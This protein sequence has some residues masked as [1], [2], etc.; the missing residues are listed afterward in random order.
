MQSREES[1]CFVCGK[2]VLCRLEFDALNIDPRGPCFG[3][4]QLVVD[5]KLQQHRYPI[6]MVIGLE[7]ESF[8]GIGLG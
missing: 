8:A 1:F 6:G 5:E 4:G 3:L 2:Y 7:I